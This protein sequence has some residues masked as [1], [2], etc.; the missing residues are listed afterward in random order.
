MQKKKLIRILRIMMIPV[1]IVSIVVFPPW[2]GIGAWVTPLPDTV[3]QQV[4]DAV[5]HYYHGRLINFHYGWTETKELVR[6]F[7][8]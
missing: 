7:Y 5:D 4:N 2:N 6:H 1:G 3:Q 8:Q